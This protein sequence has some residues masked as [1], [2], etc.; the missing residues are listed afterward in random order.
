MRRQFGCPV[1]GPNEGGTVMQ[2]WEIIKYIYLVTGRFSIH[3]F[4]L[5]QNVFFKQ[6]LLHL[7]TEIGSFYSLNWSNMLLFCF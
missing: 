1:A 2:G 4:I 7:H 6:F 5:E 3:S